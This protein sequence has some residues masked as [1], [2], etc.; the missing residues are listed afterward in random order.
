MFTKWHISPFFCLPMDKTHTHV[1]QTVRHNWCY[2]FFYYVLI[3]CGILC[4]QLPEPAKPGQLEWVGFFYFQTGSKC[5]S[6]YM[7]RGHLLTYLPNVIHVCVVT[8]HIH[9]WF[10]MERGA[11][12]ISRLSTIRSAWLYALLIEQTGDQSNWATL[13]GNSY[14][15]VPANNS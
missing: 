13:H 6:C 14:E 10:C 4:S 8:L 12:P 5:Y 15:T 2:Y 3:Y 11:E 1:K 7:T 9:N